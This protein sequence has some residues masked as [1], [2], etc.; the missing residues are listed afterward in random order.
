MPDFLLMDI[1]AKPLWMW[2]VFTSVVL[3]LLAF[4]L[5]VLHKESKEISVRE[6]LLLSAFYITM[7]VAF[8]GWVWWS[9][10]PQAGTRIP[11]GIRHREEPL[12]GQ[13]LRH[14][15]DLRLFRH[16]PR[17]PVPRALLGHPG[18]HPDARRDDRRRRGTG[19]AVRLGALVL[20]GVPHHHGREDD[21]RGR[22]GLR[23]LDEPDPE[24]HAKALPRHR[25]P[26]R[27]GVLREGA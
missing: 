1:L 13:Y 11:D 20:R 15:H 5:G 6:S 16:S 24:V 27:P 19:V 12:D 3:A 10:S 8:G 21:R 14:R 25:R 4:D 26:A 23:R 17:L 9:I 22:Q 7:G 2:L 18:G